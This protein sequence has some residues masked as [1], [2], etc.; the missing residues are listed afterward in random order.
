[1]KANRELLKAFGIAIRLERERLDIPQDELAERAHLH[2][3][4]VG[5][6]ERGERNIGLNNIHAISIALDI[7]MANLMANTTQLLQRDI[8]NAARN[9]Q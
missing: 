5:S 8:K 4:Y 1:M 6:V 2:R 9:R 7:S 3:T